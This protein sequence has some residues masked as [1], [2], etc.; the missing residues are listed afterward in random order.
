MLKRITSF[1]IVICIL[2]CLS[3][4]GTK[5]TNGDVS[6]TTS[7]IETG[8][9]EKTENVESIYS[10]AET[11]STNVSQSEISATQSVTTKAEQQAQHIHK[12]SSATCTSPKT[13]S[14]GATAGVALGHNFSSAT[15]TSPKICS[16]CGATNGSALGH[17]YA[18]ATCTLPKKCSRCGATTGSALGHN[19]VNN[20]C[21]RC[22]KVD[23]DSLPVGLDSLYLIDS[24]SYRYQSGSITDSFGNS[25]ASEHLFYAL[26]NGNEGYSIFNLNGRYSKFTGTLI[27]PKGSSNNCNYYINIYVDNNLVYSK[28]G[29]TITTGKINFN[30]NV[31][32]GQQLTIRCGSDRW[33]LDQNQKLG[34]VNAQ[35]TK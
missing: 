32:G 19:Y 7:H 33:A 9:S 3:A 28:S 14:C 15:C 29:I 18:N 10:A 20:K 21:T 4:C 17:S 12:Y 26:S 27:T 31:Q 1:L 24:S 30:I 2:F 5:E 11:T 13:C 22:G 23:P 6:T 8:E 16:R 34:I 35:L 25:Y